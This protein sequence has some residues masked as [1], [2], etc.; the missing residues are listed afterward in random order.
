MSLRLS[1]TS[2]FMVI[3]HITIVF[4]TLQGLKAKNDEH[5]PGSLV[6]SSLLGKR[7]KKQIRGIMKFRRPHLS[8]QTTVPN[9]CPSIILCIARHQKSP[10]THQTN[11]SAKITVQILFIK[12]PIWCSTKNPSNYESTRY[13]QN[14]PTP[15]KQWKSSALWTCIW[16]TD[17]N[18][19]YASYIWIKYKPKQLDT[20][21][22]CKNM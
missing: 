11:K 21:C 4:V 7:T 12:R 5:K 19:T 8:F 20:T 22:M 2:W 14:W 17:I 18:N 15:A 10:T 13:T 9:E 3:H 16:E 1:E 6:V